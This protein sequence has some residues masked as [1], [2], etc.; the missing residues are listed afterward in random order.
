M[1]SNEYKG[2]RRAL[3]EG[4]VMGYYD[5]LEYDLAL[6]ELNLCWEIELEEE[7]KI[8]PLTDYQK[9][10]IKRLKKYY[11]KGDWVRFISLAMRMRRLDWIVG[12]LEK[13]QGLIE[14]RIANLEY[15]GA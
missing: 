14:E 11:T 1:T 8:K 6:L 4:Y 13:F 15:Y 12:D 7:H 2:M 5:T 10:E 3:E 9:Q